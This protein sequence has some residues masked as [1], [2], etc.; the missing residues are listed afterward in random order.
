MLGRY[1][2]LLFGLAS[3]IGCAGHAPR[4]EDGLHAELERLVASFGGD[5]GIFAR[6]LDRSGEIAFRADE[7]FPTASLV[8]IPILCAVYDA[9]ERGALDLHAAHEYSSSRARTD[10]ED[11]LALAKDGAKIS[12]SKLVHLMIAL[13][14]NTASVW[15]QELVGGGEAVNRWLASAGFDHTRVNSRTSGREAAYEA[16]GWG[17]TSPREMAEFLVRIREQRLISPRADEDMHRVLTRTYWD[18]EAVGQIPPWV[19]VASKQGAVSKSRSEVLLVSAPAGDYVLCVI[20]K[21]QADASWD[22]DNAGFVLLR[23]VSRAV[24]RHWG[25]AEYSPATGTEAWR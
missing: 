12:L 25:G 3:L 21:N 15:C 24:W 19:S 2:V 23:D 1:S 8:K 20:T 4:A 10:G 14:D 18:D 13:S 5:V 9:I 22:S 16:F 7:T 6:R 11:V 17:Q